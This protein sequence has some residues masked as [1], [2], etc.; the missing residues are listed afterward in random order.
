M[1]VAKVYSRDGKLVAVMAQEAMIRVPD[2]T[3]DQLQSG[4]ETSN[5]PA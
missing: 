3:L 2:E 5:T 1:A 4:S